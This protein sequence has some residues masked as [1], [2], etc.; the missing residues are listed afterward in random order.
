MAGRWFAKRFPR[1]LTSDPSALARMAW[2]PS[3]RAPHPSELLDPDP[4]VSPGPPPMTP[5][6]RA[7]LDAV[8]ADPDADEPRLRYAE[9][10]DRQGDPRGEFIRSQI[11]EFH[12]GGRREEDRGVKDGLELNS[13]SAPSA[14][15]AVNRFLQ[16]LA[17]WSARDVVFRRGFAE[18]MSLAGRAFISISDGLFRT[19]PLRDVRLV[20]VAPYMDEL[21]QAPNL[22][23]LDRLD[24]SGNRIG[25]TGVRELTNSPHLTRLR[26]LDLTANDLDDD[27]AA[28]LAGSPHLDGL[29]VLRIANNPGLTAGTVEALRDR[30][31][32]GVLL[33]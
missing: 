5:H 2:N 28:A 17:P 14:P 10:C 15:S 18:A 26:E 32:E 31:G 8:L 11:E 20:A 24:L 3:Y 9:W 16:M 4:F 6:E 33:R 1:R 27:T 13:S 19:T 12:R 7:L 21:A 29:S 30:F 22:T 25:P 23:K